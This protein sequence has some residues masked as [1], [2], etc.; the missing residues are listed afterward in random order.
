LTR[1]SAGGLLARP[2]LRTTDERGQLFGLYLESEYQTNAAYRFAASSLSLR[3]TDRRG[4]TR[5]WRV[6]SSLGATGVVLGAVSNG[7]S[8]P[9]FDYDYG[10]GLGLRMGGLVEHSGDQLLS[11]AYDGYW[12]RTL[13]G[14]TQANWLQN[15]GVQ[16]RTPRFGG[17]YGAVD[18][19]M[20]WRLNEF[21]SLPSIWRHSNQLSLFLGLTG[22]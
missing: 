18:Y 1:L 11:V 19:Q 3:R 6:G 5:G 15:V 8:E 20:Y 17:L 21:G 12:L 16:M 4:T 7:V 13:H 22:R 10:P 14:P 9:R 2:D